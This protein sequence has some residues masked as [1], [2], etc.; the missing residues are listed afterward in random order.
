V[1]SP[2]GSKVHRKLVDAKEIASNLLLED[3]EDETSRFQLSSLSSRDSDIY[4]FGSMASAPS[5]NKS[6]TPVTPSIHSPLPQHETLPHVS[7]MSTGSTTEPSVDITTS[8]VP[9]CPNI[10]G[11]TTE[12]SVDI[13]TSSVPVCPNIAEG[14][15]SPNGTIPFTAGNRRVAM[16]DTGYKYRG[17]LCITSRYKPQKTCAEHLREMC[18]DPDIIASIP[19]LSFIIDDSIEIADC[20]SDDEGVLL[21]SCQLLAIIIFTYDLGMNA[22]H[23]SENFYYQLNDVLRKRN[24][25]QM[26]QWR[27]F[28]YYFL[29]ALKTLPP[30]ADENNMVTLYRGTPNIDE[31][32]ANY[33]KGR[34]IYWSGF[35][36]A[37][38]E[39]S[40]AGNFAGLDG[41]ILRLSVVSGRDISSYSAIQSDSEV[42]LSP[43]IKFL[44][45]GTL[46]KESDGYL[47]LDLMEIVK[48]ER[49]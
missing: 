24:A 6:A 23:I 36:S 45:T 20:L 28:F 5:R 41:V 10:A 43:N 4:S 46:Q 11:S 3:E 39:K 14:P 48:A 31:I 29:E 25:S 49:R 2:Q 42:L 9:M 32:R 19:Q 7:P 33:R 1:Q 37:T 26:L 8:S 40:V 47:Y 21:S 27:P 34:K 16:L 38:P 17:L 12:P 30:V 15:S 44:V 18:S 35:S 13:T 22:D